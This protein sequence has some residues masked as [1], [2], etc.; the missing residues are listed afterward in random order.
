MTRVKAMRPVI[1]QTATM[2]RSRQLPPAATN[3]DRRGL[4]F[5]VPQMRGLCRAALQSIRS[6]SKSGNFPVESKELG[7][8]AGNSCGLS[9]LAATAGEEPCSNLYD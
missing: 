3:L 6:G 7:K 5:F 4:A 2:A 8:Q 1:K 9:G